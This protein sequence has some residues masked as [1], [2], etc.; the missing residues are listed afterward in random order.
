METVT[1]LNVTS[2][3]NGSQFFSLEKESPGC[4]G[5]DIISETRKTRKLFPF[6]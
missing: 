2:N 1:H 3:F 5:N 4:L 6:C